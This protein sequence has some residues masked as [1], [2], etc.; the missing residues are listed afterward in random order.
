MSNPFK[1]L[2]RSALLAMILGVIGT[3]S[4]MAGSVI[5]INGDGKLAGCENPAPANYIVESFQ[6]SLGDA[7]IRK[8]SEQFLSIPSDRITI[9]DQEQC[10]VE[11]DGVNVCDHAIQKLQLGSSTITEIKTL[12]SGYLWILK[13]S[14]GTSFLLHHVTAGSLHWFNYYEAPTTGGVTVEEVFGVNCQNAT[15]NC[16]PFSQTPVLPSPLPT[17]PP[18]GVTTLLSLEWSDPTP[19]GWNSKVATPFHFGYNLYQPAGSQQ[20]VLHSVTGRYSL[21]EKECTHSTFP[22]QAIS[23]YSGSIGSAV[24][25]SILD[26]WSKYESPSS[27]CVTVSAL[28][29]FPDSMSLVRARLWDGT[30]DFTLSDLKQDVVT[31]DAVYSGQE[32]SGTAFKID[33]ETRLITPREFRVCAGSTQKGTAIAE[34]SYFDQKTRLTEDSDPTTRLYVALPREVRTWLDRSF[35]FVIDIVLLYLLMRFSRGWLGDRRTSGD[36][37]SQAHADFPGSDSTSSAGSLS[38]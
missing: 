30:R 27:G 24:S 20:Y 33:S 36:R 2:L 37:R 38:A 31:T 34:F 14:D 15:S 4:V 6:F 12:Q 13:A 26:F 11:E 17:I 9:L 22:R 28:E 25:S 29:P 1:S 7:G 18:I 10:E 35:A 23:G 8:A 21:A 3:K 32:A 5:L 16:Q 19:T